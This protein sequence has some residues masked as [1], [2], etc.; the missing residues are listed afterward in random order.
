MR[1]RDFITL[2]GSAATTWHLPAGAQGSIPVVGFLHSA[3]RGPNEPLLAAFVKGLA[4]LG[5]VE[6]RNLRMEYRWADGDFDRLPA[7]AADLVQR[8]VDVL[9]AAGGNVS[10]LSAHAA[11]STIPIVF[12]GVDDPVRLGVVTS[13]N[14]PGGNLT[15][16]SLFNAVLSMKRLELLRELVPAATAIALLINPRNPTSDKQVED[17]QSA[18][19]SN[20]QPIQVL[21]ATNASEIAAAFS[22]MREQRASALIVGADPLFLNLRD[23]LIVLA[24]RDRLPVIYTQREFA[25]TGGL[26]SYGVSFPENYHQAALYVGRIIK[27]EK[28]GDLPVVQPTRFELV[29]NLKTAKA[30]GFEIPPT[31]LARADEVIE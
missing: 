24:A 30:L 21:K 12:T 28:P 26:I 10:V 15:G 5:L 18:A 14:H 11:T 19:P 2:L 27:G 17:L 25:T 4:E 9:V 1:R 20:I 31:L 23:Q 6:G 8:R 29:I 16:V 13:F 22:A 3:S 7:L